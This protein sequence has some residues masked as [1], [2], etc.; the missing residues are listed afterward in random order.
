V[1]TKKRINVYLPQEI[2]DWADRK[3]RRLSLELDQDLN[4][5]N[6]IEMALNMM[7]EAEEQEGK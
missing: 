6:V 2:I 5:S 3:A 1:A 7:R 4:R